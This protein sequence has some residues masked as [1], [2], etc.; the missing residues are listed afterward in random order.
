MWGSEERCSIRC[1]VSLWP[2]SGP[3]QQPCPELDRAAWPKRLDT[4]HG[5]QACGVRSWVISLSDLDL[6]Q[7]QDAAAAHRT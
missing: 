6:A 5:G 3:T 7:Q 2:E 1:F 4:E